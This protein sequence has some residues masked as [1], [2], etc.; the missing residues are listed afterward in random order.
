MAY[1]AWNETTSEAQGSR[2]RAGT[3]NLDHGGLRITVDESDIRHPRWQMWE[4]NLPNETSWSI[5]RIV[6]NDKELRARNLH[7][8]FQQAMD[9]CR[10][11]HITKGL[12]SG[13]QFDTGH[14]DYTCTDGPVTTLQRRSFKYGQ[15]LDFAWRIKRIEYNGI[16]TNYV[17]ESRKTFMAVYQCRDANKED[18]IIVNNDMMGGDTEPGVPKRAI[19]RCERRLK[20]E[21]GGPSAARIVVL[22]YTEN[23]TMS[24]TS[25]NDEFKDEV[26]G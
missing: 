15:V 26:Q 2:R 23:E 19:F 14:I 24:F 8:K 18:K 25:R 21:S 22:E 7:T 5:D 9:E 6:C 17:D 11:I 13:V 20:R 3:N 4:I 1:A 12:F 16:R 10:P